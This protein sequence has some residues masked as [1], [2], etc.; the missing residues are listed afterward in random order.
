MNQ[1]KNSAALPFAVLMLAGNAVAQMPAPHGTTLQSDPFV[2]QAEAAYVAHLTAERAG[3]LALYKQ[4][5]AKGAIDEMVA[6]LRQRGQSD[7]D[8]PAALKRVSAYS[9]PLNGYRFL[10]ADGAGAA[11]RLF[12]RK[13]WKNS[14]VEMVDFLGYVVH[15]EE[16]RWKVGC[17]VNATG[18]KLGL[19]PGGKLQER[20]VDEAA[21]HRCLSLK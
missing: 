20:T 9:T 5:R 10:K 17:V 21:G 14:D 16:G 13:D 8:F 6:G 1:S 11:G 15:W 19:G 12:Y 2:A 18:T 3:D 4:H 7:K